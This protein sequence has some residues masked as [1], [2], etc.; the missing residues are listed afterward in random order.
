MEVATGNETK[1]AEV[2]I[3]KS[4][5]VIVVV[6]NAKENIDDVAHQVEVNAQGHVNEAAEIDVPEAGS[7]EEVAVGIVTAAE[8]HREN[9]G[10]DMLG[11]RRPQKKS[12]LS[13]RGIS[14]PFSACNLLLV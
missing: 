9:I 7:T 8:R 3:A 6:A 12:C 14:V 5:V 13:R 4:V 10:L 11:H 1:E 2:K